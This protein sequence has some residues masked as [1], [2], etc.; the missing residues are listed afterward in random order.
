MRFNAY[1]QCLPSLS[2]LNKLVVIDRAIGI[3]IKRLDQPKG[4]IIVKPLAHRRHG[5]FQRLGIGTSVL[6]RNQ[7][8]F[9]MR[10]AE[11]PHPRRPSSAST[12][13][14]HTCHS[15]HTHVTGEKAVGTQATDYA[16]VT[17]ATHYSLFP[18][19]LLPCPSCLT[20]SCSKSC[21]DPLHPCPLPSTSSIRRS[22]RKRAQYERGWQGYCFC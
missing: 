5:L 22:I 11:S 18:F 8:H 7:V 21:C 12:H 10:R 14:S 16:Q 20:A 2:P 3:G 1:H 19:S 13:T 4:F 9:G 17:C 6:R 15:C